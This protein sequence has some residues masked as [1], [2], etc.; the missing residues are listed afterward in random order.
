MLLTRLRPAQV[1]TADSRE[2]ETSDNCATLIESR[3]QVLRL[4][5]LRLEGGCEPRAYPSAMADKGFRKSAVGNPTTQ[6]GAV[7]NP[8]SADKRVSPRATSVA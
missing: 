7:G 6:K 4:P 2:W 3:F 1:F 5:A 8:G